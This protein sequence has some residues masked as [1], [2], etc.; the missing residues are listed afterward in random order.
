MDRGEREKRCGNGTWAPLAARSIHWA[1]LGLLDLFASKVAA[2]RHQVSPSRIYVGALPV[3][4]APLFTKGFPATYLTPK[5]L[6]RLQGRAASVYLAAPCSRV[7]PI[8]RP[9]SLGGVLL[10]ARLSL[11]YIISPPAATASSSRQL[12][13]SSPSKQ[14]F[15]RASTPV[16]SVLSST[17]AAHAV[18][19]PL[20]TPRPPTDRPCISLDCSII[21]AWVR[22]SCWALAARPSV[23]GLRLAHSWRFIRANI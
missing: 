19:S 20:G 11:E 10:S 15:R 4:S 12:L 7:R 9:F 13:V 3:S 16:S 2:K 23:R 22:T 5:S 17:V 18:S 21:R 6:S 1:K 14:R 8:V